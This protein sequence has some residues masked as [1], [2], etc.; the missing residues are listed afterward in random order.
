MVLE[1]IEIF[2]KTT[3]FK[4]HHHINQNSP[5]KTPTKKFNNIS[6]LKNKI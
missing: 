5:I 1:N 6:N 3:G 4:N 2:N